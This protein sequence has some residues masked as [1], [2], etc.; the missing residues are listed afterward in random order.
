MTLWVVLDRLIYANWDFGGSARFSEV[1]WRETLVLSGSN[2]TLVVSDR[3]ELLIWRSQVSS[4]RV[5]PPP[6]HLQTTEKC[7]V[8]NRTSF[9]CRVLG[10]RSPLWSRNGSFPLQSSWSQADKPENDI[11]SSQEN[12]QRRFLL[13]LYVKARRKRHILYET[14]SAAAVGFH[15]NRQAE[16]IPK[17]EKQHLGSADPIQTG[18]PVF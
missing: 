5:H 9:F 7:H 18:S 14:R 16:F 2:A 8:R 12:P 17:T 13:L 4:Q 10:L 11:K 6:P 3:D 1:R 15:P